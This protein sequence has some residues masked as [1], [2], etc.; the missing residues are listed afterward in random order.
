MWADFVVVMACY[1][2]LDWLEFEKGAIREQSLV[3]EMI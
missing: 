2:Q 1:V 3:Y